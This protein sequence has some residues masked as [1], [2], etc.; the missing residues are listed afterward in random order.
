M[1]KLARRSKSIQLCPRDADGGQAQ[2]FLVTAHFSDKHTE[3]FTHQVI[4]SM[5]NGD[6]AAVSADGVVT[7]KQLGETAVMVRAAGQVSSVGVGVIG[8]PVP[9]Y[10]NVP[11]WNFIDEPI[12]SKLKKFHIIPSDVSSDSEFL[13]R[14]CLDLTGTLP[15]PGRMRQF[16]A[17][18][19][20]KKREKVVDALLASPEFTDYWTFRFSDIFRVAIFS[21]RPDSEVE[22]GVLGVD[23]I[24]HRRESPL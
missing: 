5:N 1:R 24:E 7:P 10:P 3:D 8:P 13:R 9:N 6:V 11:R 15:P 16:V 14:V 12:F 22:P 4:Y 23:S 2:A 17:S 19:D 18:R 21:E 20:P